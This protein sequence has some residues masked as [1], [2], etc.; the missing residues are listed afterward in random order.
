MTGRSTQ[1]QL[2]S[3][4]NITGDFFGMHRGV[5]ETASDRLQ[6]RQ[7]HSRERTATNLCMRI[8]VRTVSAAAA[9]GEAGVALAT[10]AATVAAVATPVGAAAVGLVGG[11]TLVCSLE[12]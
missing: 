4:G 3:L 8:R 5:I 6:R 2:R 9:R 10:V 11:G 7:C 12:Q 1:P